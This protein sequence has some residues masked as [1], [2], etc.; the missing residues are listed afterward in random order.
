MAPEMVNQSGYDKAIDWWA[1]GIML[2][3]M[4]VGCSPFRI[5]KNVNISGDLYFEKVKK[6]GVRFP[7]QKRYAIQYSPEFKDLILQLLN[8]DRRLRLG[9]GEEDYKAVLKHPAFAKLNVDRL[10]NRM[11]PAPLQPEVQDI[12]MLIEQANQDPDNED[13][14]KKTHIA[15]QDRAQV[16]QN[17]DKFNAFGDFD[18]QL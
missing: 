9:F 6:M 1:L 10:L 2:Y 12:S 17:Q 3:E 7:D 16:R 11:I 4:L 13:S 5:G 18:A 14:L 8:K 15:S